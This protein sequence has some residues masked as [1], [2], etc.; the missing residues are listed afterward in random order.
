MIYDYVACY[1][2][3]I[4]EATL[5][6]ETFYID[7]Q[8]NRIEETTQDYETNASGGMKDTKDKVQFT[9]LPLDLLD[10]VLDVMKYGAEKYDWDNWRKVEAEKY[11]DAFYRHYRELEKGEWLDDESGLPHVGHIAT[12]ILFYCA[13]KMQER[14]K[15]WQETNYVK[16][17]IM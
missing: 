11:I 13:I 7:K 3:G 4:A 1:R 10:H 17:M 15:K 14:E 2:K 12:D 8:G 6:G 16:N 9:K 5:N